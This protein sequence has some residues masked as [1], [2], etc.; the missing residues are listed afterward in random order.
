WAKTF[1]SR[2]PL[3]YQRITRSP[4]WISSP[5]SSAS[6]VAVRLN[7]WIT[8]V[9][10]RISSTASGMS[11]GF[12]RS[13][14]SA[15]GCSSSASIPV[16]I[17]LRVVSLPAKAS[18]PRNVR[19]SRSLSLSPST[20]ALRNRMT[21]ESATCSAVWRS[22]CSCRYADIF[23][24]AGPAVLGSGSR[25]GDLELLRP[26]VEVVDVDLRHA[27][28]LGEHPERH[29]DG[30]I[31][32][33]VALAVF[34]ELVDR[35]GHAR[36]DVR[37]QGGGRPWREHALQDLF[38]AC[39]L[40]RVH[41]EQEIAE[42]L[43]RQHLVGVEEDAATSRGERPRIAA[44]G[45]DVGMPEQ[46]PAAAAVRQRVAMDRSLAPQVGEQRVWWPVRPPPHVEEV[47]A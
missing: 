22:I 14:S 24:N 12:A 47:D 29:R 1:S 38:E 23:E 34:D 39:V 21:S 18:S 33:E 11:A 44:R 26:G 36:S 5:A 25:R 16:L 3:P 8:V 31:V 40:R 43:Q 10:R 27:H 32:D 20:T 4:S 35:A 45:G 28:E 37:L 9:Q 46:R 17:V 41:V 19:I 13:S 42:D 15:S 7:H 2:G 30:E 6:R